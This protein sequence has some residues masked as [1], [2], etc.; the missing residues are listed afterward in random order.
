MAKISTT[1]LTELMHLA[2]KLTLPDYLTNLCTICFTFMKACAFNINLPM[3]E[4]ENM[5]RSDHA[6]NSVKCTKQNIW[7][8]LRP[9]KGLKAL[10]SP[11]VGCITALEFDDA[12]L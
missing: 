5:N 4:I 1:R 10:V 8:T 3:Q 11:I 12:S 9:A 2:F 6:W 7:R